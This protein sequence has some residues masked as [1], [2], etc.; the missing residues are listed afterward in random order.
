MTSVGVVPRVIVLDLEVL[1][2]P[3]ECFHCHTEK[4]THGACAGS[5][6]LWCTSRIT[7]WEAIGWD[8]KAEL[9][10][11]CGAFWSYPDQSL[12]WFDAQ[13]LEETV[14]DF[15]AAKPLIVSFN[16]LRFDLPLMRALLRERA[17]RTLG[18][19]EGP[20][21]TSMLL[22][23]HPLMLLCDAFKTLCATSYDILDQLWRQDPQTKKIRSINSLQ[24]LRQANGLGYAS[25]KGAEI[26]G[27]WRKEHYAK[28]LNHC[29]ADVNDTRKLFERIL[30]HGGLHRLDGSFVELPCPDS[31]SMNDIDAMNL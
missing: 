26:P 17:R 29:A 6:G 16:G 21:D 12:L 27:L 25:S 24:A 18:T 28:V 8:R 30:T 2:G 7:Q 10:L 3:G 20:A 23:Q 11:S 9:G 13:S 14:Q 1:Y 22:A 31:L 15:V 19:D 4:E 5:E